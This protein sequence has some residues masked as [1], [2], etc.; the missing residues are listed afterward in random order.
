MIGRAAGPCY[1]PWFDDSKGHEPLLRKLLMKVEFS[2]V[3]GL[4]FFINVANGSSVRAT[5]VL[6][7]SF[8][9][10]DG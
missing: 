9:G 7:T 10:G 8:D 5:L 2:T 1:I 6:R 3:G 4:A